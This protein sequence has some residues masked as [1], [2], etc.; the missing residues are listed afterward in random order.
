MIVATKKIFVNAVNTSH[1]HNNN[2]NFV[3]SKREW[4]FRSRKFDSFPKEKIFPYGNNCLK[5]FVVQTDHVFQIKLCKKICKK[6]PSWFFYF[7]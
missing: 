7:L 4:F 6:P 5:G 2:L 3:S 1:I